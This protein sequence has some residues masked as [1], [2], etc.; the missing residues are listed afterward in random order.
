[1]KRCQAGRHVNSLATCF[2]VT[3]GVL[4]NLPGTHLTKKEKDRV[5]RV[6]HDYIARH[7]DNRDWS[8]AL[9]ETEQKENWPSGQRMKKHEAQRIVLGWLYR[10]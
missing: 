10:S 1:M 9:V 4:D 8:P 6:Y 5:S 3:I 7:I 2:P